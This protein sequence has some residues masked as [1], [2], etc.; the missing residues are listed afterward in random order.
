M[1]YIVSIHKHTPAAETLPGDGMFGP[2]GASLC[3]SPATEAGCHWSP[4]RLFLLGL[5]ANGEPLLGAKDGEVPHTISEA[6][7]ADTDSCLSR[8]RHRLP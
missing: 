1:S 7:P 6:L 4:E 5:W 2:A 3:L 8:L